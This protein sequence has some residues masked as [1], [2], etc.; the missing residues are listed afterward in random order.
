MPDWEQYI[1]VIQTIA[2]KLPESGCND[3]NFIAQNISEMG[4]FYFDINRRIHEN[5][6]LYDVYVK[7]IFIFILL[8]KMLL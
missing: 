4:S 7:Y 6:S 5:F 2:L 1:D 3:I 8:K